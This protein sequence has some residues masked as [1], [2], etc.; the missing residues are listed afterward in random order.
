MNDSFRYAPLLAFSLVVSKYILFSNGLSSYDWLN[1]LLILIVGFVLTISSIKKRNIAYFPFKV[2]WLSSFNILVLA[3][4][5][6]GV[7]VALLASNFYD[8]ELTSKEALFAGFIQFFQVEFIGLV[9]IS[10]LSL[11]FKK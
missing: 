2:V 6:S 9:V 8:V 5:V 11:V 3:S 7:L 4:I 1:T 10:A